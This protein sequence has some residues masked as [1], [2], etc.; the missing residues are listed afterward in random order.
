MAE[1][2]GSFT[3]GT[4]ADYASW[5]LAIADIAATLTGDL[6][7]TQVAPVPADSGTAAAKAVNLDGNTLTLT[8]DTP[9]LGRPAGGHTTTLTGASDSNHII[10]LQVTGTGSLV[11]EQLN[12]RRTGTPTASNSIDV[13]T[14]GPDVDIHDCIV[15][16]SAT[17]GTT[18]GIKTV[19]GVGAS[20]STD[21]NVWNCAVSGYTTGGSLAAGNSSV[22]TVENITVWD[23]D[24]NIDAASSDGTFINCVG[25]SN[26]STADFANTGS[27]DG[28]N[29]A[30][31]DASAGDGNW[32]T[33]TGNLTTIVPA[34]EFVSVLTTSADM[35][36]LAA[37]GSLDTGGAA[38]TIAA[39]TAGMRGNAR[40]GPDTDYSIGGDEFVINPTVTSVDPDD[41]E[42]AGGTAV[43]VTGTG[44]A[45]DATVRFGST[46]ATSV[47]VVGPTSITCVSPAGTGVVDVSVTNTDSGVG[48]LAGAFSYLG[49]LVSASVSV[50]NRLGEAGSIWR[51]SPSLGDVLNKIADNLAFLKLAS[52]QDDFDEFKL[53]M[54]DVDMLGE[55][56]PPTYGT[57]YVDTS[58]FDVQVPRRSG[59]GKRT[60]NKAQSETLVGVLEAL[61]R[62]AN[63]LATIKTSSQLTDFAAFKAAMADAKNLLKADDSRV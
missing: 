57:T 50:P 45:A 26:S 32:S 15:I 2:Q 18:V 49:G 16:S 29:C 53:A 60:L 44:F 62:A 31:E 54:E 3:V 11:I 10:P 13:E 43:T 48:T 51:T 39:N 61:N 52:Q 21:I 34:T 7:L 14:Q 22:L 25:F 9:H 37:A 24:T 47:V 55:G 40:P 35:V 46:Q 58:S 63:I 23:C 4:G 28:T 30:S 5:D 27:A 41:G 59:E 12:L 17:S 36:K 42:A 19:G 8:S 20:G 6:T 33:G 56:T 38:T 1:A